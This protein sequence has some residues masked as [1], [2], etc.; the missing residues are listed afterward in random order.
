MYLKIKIIKQC[1]YTFNGY[2]SIKIWFLNV[3]NEKC[4]CINRISYVVKY[5]L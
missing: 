4:L 2:F 3:D 5:S 1:L